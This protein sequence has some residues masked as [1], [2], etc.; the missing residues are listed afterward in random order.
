MGLTP[1][2]GLVMGTRSGDIDPAVPAYL[3]RVAGLG[4]A[5]VD[6]ALNRRSG[7]LGLADVSDVRELTSRATAGDD[8]ATFALDVYCYR[9]RCYVGA[10]YAALGRLDAITFTAGVG[11]NS[12][13]V[14]ERSLAGL[15][16]LGV[17]VDPVRNQS[18]TRGARRISPDGAPVAVLVVP[19]DEE[20]EIAA[21]ALAVVRACSDTCSA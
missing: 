10:Y 2:Q 3:D 21:Q 16:R 14:R 8:R 9:I 1:L 15:E 17:M 5:A 4:P 6:E 12:S 13:L 18:P 19:T 7:L 20:R 11:E